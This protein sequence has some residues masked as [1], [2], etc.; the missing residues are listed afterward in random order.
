MTRS[1]RNRRQAWASTITA[2]R[3][4]ALQRV[5]QFPPDKFAQADRAL[6]TTTVSLSITR[7]VRE[8]FTM[9]VEE[10]DGLL[11]M[12]RRALRAGFELNK[13]DIARMALAALKRLPEEDFMAMAREL[14]KL[15]PG[16]P[17]KSRKE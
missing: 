17:T 14:K 7:A 5:P 2:E 12:K 9:L 8:T 13:S 3:E 1:S 4:S 16:K 6:L 10:R 15:K 11:E